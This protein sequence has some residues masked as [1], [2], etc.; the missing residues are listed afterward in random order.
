M[1]KMVFSF[2]YKDGKTEEFNFKNKKN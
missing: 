2:F 1:L